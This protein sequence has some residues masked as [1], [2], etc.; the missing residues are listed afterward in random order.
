MSGINPSAISEQAKQELQE[1]FNAFDQ[2]KAS[3]RRQSTW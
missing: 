2:A 3:K 1:F